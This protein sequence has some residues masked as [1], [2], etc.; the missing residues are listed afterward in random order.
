MSRVI[1]LRLRKLETERR[2]SS[3]APT[4]RVHLLGGAS[5]ECEAQIQAMIAEGKAAEDDMCIF[6]VPGVFPK[7]MDTARRNSTAVQS[8]LQEAGHAALN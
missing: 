4:G 5:E 1:E 3:T 8:L 2:S 7:W 6:M